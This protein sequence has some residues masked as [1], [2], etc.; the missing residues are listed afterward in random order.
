MGTLC[1]AR[2]LRGA[3]KRDVI[4]DVAWL[5]LTQTR[6]RDTDTGRDN[7]WFTVKWAT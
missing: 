3:E 5:Q 6:E 2:K 4:G 7:H 1:M